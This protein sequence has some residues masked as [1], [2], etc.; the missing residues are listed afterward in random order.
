MRLRPI[1]GK[2]EFTRSLRTSDRQTAERLA[3]IEARP[4][5]ALWRERL[6]WWPVPLLAGVVF[7][8]AG[9]QVGAVIGAL[10]LMPIVV[11]LFIVFLLLAALF[12]WGLARGLNLPSDQ[13][14]TL[15]FSLGTRIPS[16]SCRSP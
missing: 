13:G 12:A 3:W 4:A 5:R 15:A 2:R 11:P 14:R 16:W 8:I 7:L 10:A 1:V 6:A 9:A